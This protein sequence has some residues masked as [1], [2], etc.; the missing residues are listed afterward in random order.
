MTVDVF[1]I[2][3]VLGV[4]GYF[5]GLYINRSAH[6]ELWDEMASAGFKSVD[7]P[8]HDDA[9]R[10]AKSLGIEDTAWFEAKTK[11]GR[12]ISFLALFLGFSPVIVLFFM[13]I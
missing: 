13:T 2:F 3:P 7:K 1:T 10:V 12:R 11:I 5:F 6:W 4:A 9:V 8:E